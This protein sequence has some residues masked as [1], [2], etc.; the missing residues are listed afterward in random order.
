MRQA[1]F[2]PA[3]VRCYL[4]ILS[5]E[6]DLSQ[7]HY[8]EAVVIIRSYL[9]IANGISSDKSNRRIVVNCMTCMHN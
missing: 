2:A 7:K 4:A 8:L 5:I 6:Y 1:P 9:A 3:I